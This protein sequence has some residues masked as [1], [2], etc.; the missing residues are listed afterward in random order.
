VGLLGHCCPEARATTCPP[1]ADTACAGRSVSS[2]GNDRVA[3]RGLLR[4]TAPTRR[5]RLLMLVRSQSR[6]RSTLDSPKCINRSGLDGSMLEPSRTNAELTACSAFVAAKSSER[7]R[8]RTTRAVRAW[9]KMT[10]ARSPCSASSTT[11][12][13]RSRPPPRST[14]MSST[15]RSGSDTRG[16]TGGDRPASDDPTSC[17]FDENAVGWGMR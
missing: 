15:M 7:L 14:A 13:S 11:V 17:W 16:V 3:G 1:G 9:S 12:G 4:I 5:R 6:V 8:S 10:R 2:D